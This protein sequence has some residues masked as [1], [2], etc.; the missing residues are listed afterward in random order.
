[1][2]IE[3]THICFFCGEKHATKHEIF[4]D[5]TIPMPS[6]PSNWHK[7][8]TMIFCSNECLLG[9]IKRFIPN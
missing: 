8:D 5:D 2:N 6:L 9:Y 3:Y 7:L 4:S 1:M